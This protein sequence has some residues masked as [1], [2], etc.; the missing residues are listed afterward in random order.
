M[1]KSVEITG[2]STNDID[3]LTDDETKVLITKS[4]NGDLNA[5]EKLVNGN[6]K[7]VLSILKKFNGKV[8][9]MDDLFQIGC[10]GLLKA[11]DNFDPSFDVK[12][13]TY[14][15]PLILGEMRRYVRDNT[16]FRVSRSLK[17]LSYDILAYKENYLKKYGAEASSSVIA[18]DLNISEYDVY[19]ALES[20]SPTISI[21]DPVYQDDGEA[22]YLIDQLKDK[23]IN[24]FSKDQLIS[25]KYALE[26][27]KDKE[28]E[29][30]IKRYVI[31]KTQTELAQEYNISQAQV[32]RIEKS[33]IERARKLID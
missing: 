4:R 14:A 16:P 30:L 9:N 13:S 6:L 5:R 12:L 1:K 18:K 17:E 26:K 20:L 32:S 31:G 21:Y 25:L 11:I 27:L 7:L 23:S 15:V 3:V 10:I 29:I 24:E 19:N 33:A 28:K 22:I 8:D 2:I